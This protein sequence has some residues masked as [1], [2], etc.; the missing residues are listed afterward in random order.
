MDTK[1][2]EVDTKVSNLST[3]VQDLRLQIDHLIPHQTS[4]QGVAYKVFDTEEID[5]TKS[6]TA[7]L[8]HTPQGATSGQFDHDDDLLHWRSG[9]GVVTTLAPPPV[10]GV[11]Y[12]S[13]LPSALPLHV[14]TSRAMMSYQAPQWNYSLP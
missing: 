2:H 12:T 13:D 14:D 1:V 4:D 7:H 8:V 3:A 9:C 10:T 11:Q 6:G 5:L